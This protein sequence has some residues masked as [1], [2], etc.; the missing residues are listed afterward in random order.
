[1]ASRSRRA[2]PEP[3]PERLQKV[4]AAAGLGSRREAEAWIRAG[5]VTVNG[6]PATLGQRVSARD[7][8]R[9]DGRAL[10]APRLLAAP[11]AASLFVLHRS[12]GDSLTD[13]L[14]E[15]LPRRAGRRFTV[16][17]P[18]PRIDGGLEL[19]TADGA[20]A[21]Q[22]QRRIHSLES[23]FSAR[24][25]GSLD[26]VQLQAAQQGE[27]D[28]G[29]L[30]EVLSI[31]EGASDELASNRWYQLVVRGASGK[32]VRQLLERQGAVV[33]RVLRVAAGPV[34]LTRDLPRGRFRAATPEE[35]V[36]LLGGGAQAREAAAVARAPVSPGSRTPAPS[37]RA[38]RR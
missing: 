10:R 21:Q 12:P 2:P 3:E 11:Q 34:R 35:Q 28:D 30:V 37:R 17:S 25:R 32:Q 26:A 6:V 1:M 36:A 5:R 31:V 20:M 18:M 22:L 7:E 8:L 29:T 19:A 24:I 13:G 14:L 9:V 33:S 38:P 4:L 16:I 27:L 23:E 15:R